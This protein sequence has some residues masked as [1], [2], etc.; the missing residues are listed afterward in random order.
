MIIV[1]IV[2]HETIKMSHFDSGLIKL[3]KGWAVMWFHLLG[4]E[5]KKEIVKQSYMYK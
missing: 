3:I 4:I 5:V 2:S 1:Q